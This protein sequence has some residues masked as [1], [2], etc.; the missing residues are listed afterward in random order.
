MSETLKP[1]QRFISEAKV[2]KA[3]HPA[4]AYY[5]NLKAAQ[6]AIK[7]QPRS[8]STTAFFT[9]LIDNLEAEKKFLCDRLDK[10]C[11]NKSVY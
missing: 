10:E 3:T 1:T 7:I 5:M 9:E 6:I 4:I 8:E 11:V 2:L